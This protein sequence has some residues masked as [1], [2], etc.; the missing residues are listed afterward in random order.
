MSCDSRMRIRPRM[1]A[2]KPRCPCGDATR[3]NEHRSVQGPNHLGHFNQACVGSVAY[4]RRAMAWGLLDSG[5][6]ISEPSLRGPFHV[7]VRAGVTRG[8]ELRRKERPKFN[9][10]RW[11]FDLK[12]FDKS[13]TTLRFVTA[14]FC[15]VR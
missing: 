10:I 15:Y 3:P 2:C 9:F 13:A 11:K 6:G 4:R 1:H 5:L 7:S 8:G 12:Y 14:V